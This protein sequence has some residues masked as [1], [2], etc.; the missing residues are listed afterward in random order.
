MKTTA[1]EPTGASTQ[2]CV[3]LGQQRAVREL[4]LVL[5]AT[6]TRVD[7]AAAVQDI[8]GLPEAARPDL[9]VV[10]D[11]VAGGLSPFQLETAKTKLRPRAIICLANRLDAE[12]EVGLRGVGLA[13]LG[14]D[15][16]FFDRAEAI[17]TG[18]ARHRAGA[19]ASP[20]DH[21]QGSDGTRT[22]FAKSIQARLRQT[23]RPVNG[24]AIRM[25]YQTAAMLAG[26][27][28]RSIEL[29]VGLTVSA[30]VTVPVYG[31]LQVR[32]RVTGIPVFSLRTIAGQGTPV[33]IRRFNRAGW[34]RNLPLF[35]ELI[36]RR[37]ALVG[38]ALVD[39]DARR[40]TPEQ[41]YIRQVKPG[42]FSL[43]Q[44]RRASRIAHEGR[45]IVEW[46][47]VYKKGLVY[48]CLLML[49]VLP[50]L[51][52]GNN[53]KTPL[54]VFRLLD[55]DI[56][57]LAMTEAIQRIDQA[58]AGTEPH[59]LFFV[60][61][62]CLNK[63]VTDREYFQ[64][65]NQADDVFPDG[66]GLTIAGKLLRTPLRENI[67]GTDM[68]PFLCKMAASRGY[69]LFLLG[70]RP[71]VAAR[72]AQKLKERYR[73]SIAGTAHGYFDHATESHRVIDRINRSGAH[74]LLV[75]M[76]APVQE[77]WIARHR[78]RLDPRVAMGVGGLF[79]FYAGAIKR[80]PVWMRET[81][82]EWVYRIVQEPGRM[83]RRYVLGNPLFL[84][85]VLRWKFSP[86]PIAV[87]G[88]T[89]STEPE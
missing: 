4:R 33:T 63:I 65:L 86:Y 60:N 53:G 38:T 2:R 77:K 88:N 29:A 7:V 49:R 10:T 19:A 78:R 76:G 69:S 18:A 30:L 44:V 45:E 89:G 58:T 75:G 11:S 16:M 71:G 37:L 84:Y 41:G 5:G 35:F 87:N 1:T 50:G 43:W 3:I 80:A 79:D 83:W 66:I 72:A 39:W 51:V 64:I 70:G 52:Y 24:W 28:M 20:D 6:F 36:T 82:L 61:P 25:A 54:P 12:T 23:T 59:S 55:L 17:L 67:N 26:A 32:Y 14:N 31:V 27:I 56:A 48:D 46:E 15:Q 22:R 47:Y 42:I 62:D 85:R 8:E 40:V 68:L 73:V 21:R 34:M 9:L 81:G 57:N 13:F 74:I